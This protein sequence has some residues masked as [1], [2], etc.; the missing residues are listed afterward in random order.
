MTVTVSDPRER[1]LVEDEESLHELAR[2]FRAML[3]NLL[4]DPRKV[5]SL[6]R[7]RLAVAFDPICRPGKTFTATFSG[8][9]VMLEAGIPPRPDIVLR[10]EPAVLMKLS[11]IPP[12]PAAVKFLMSHE[13]KALVSKVLT[14][15]LR[16]KG[17]LRH[18]LGMMRFSEFLAPST[19]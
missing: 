8:G 14:G 13:G 19:A 16:I 10:C 7:M 5:R 2:F 9:R 17:L 11:R 15:E 18:P 3:L 6:E 4:K 12:G 1:L